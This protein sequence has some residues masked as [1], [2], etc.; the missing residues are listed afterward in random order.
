MCQ[1]S[2]PSLSQHVLEV[3]LFVESELSPDRMIDEAGASRVLERQ[4]LG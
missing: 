4:N 2:L 3:D 1:L